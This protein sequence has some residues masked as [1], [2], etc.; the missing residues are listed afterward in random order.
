ME[1]KGWLGRLIEE[2]YIIYSSWLEKFIY[3][4]KSANENINTGA[5]CKKFA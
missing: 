1:I 3:K 4:I 5:A 2:E